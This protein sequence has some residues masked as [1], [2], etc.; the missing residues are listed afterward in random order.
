M[1]T[2]NAIPTTT[3]PTAE[4]MVRFGRTTLTVEQAKARLADLEGLEKRLAMR[5]I[6]PTPTE[7]IEAASLRTALTRLLDRNRS[8]PNVTAA[9]VDT[10]LASLALMAWGA[11]SHPEVRHAAQQLFNRVQTETT[12]V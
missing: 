10:I 11:D 6:R 7:Q 12:D 8:L 9:D 3:L 2:N 5:G 4:P 1:T